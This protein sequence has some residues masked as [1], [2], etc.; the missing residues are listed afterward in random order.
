[1][2]TQN[3]SRQSSTSNLAFV[4]RLACDTVSLGFIFCIVPVVVQHVLFPAGSDFLA[5]TF[6]LLLVALPANA[7]IIFFFNKWT[8]RVLS[9]T[10]ISVNITL[11]DN[12]IMLVA[13]YVAGSGGRLDILFVTSNIL[14]LVCNFNCASVARSTKE[15]ILLFW[16]IDRPIKEKPATYV[17]LLLVAGMIA[18]CLVDWRLVYL[19]AVLLVLVLPM[20]VSKVQRAMKTRV[21]V[22]PD[23][24]KR[25]SRAFTAPVF[26]RSTLSHVV[27]KTALAVLFIFTLGAVFS[28]P[29]LPVCREMVLPG[30]S[31]LPLT[32]TLLVYTLAFFTLGSSLMILFWWL[33]RRHHADRAV[34]E[35]IAVICLFFAILGL[36]LPY[37]I[38]GIAGLIPAPAYQVWSLANN[39]FFAMEMLYVYLI[40]FEFIPSRRVEF[41]GQ[42]LPILIGTTF[43]LWV[44]PVADTLSTTSTFLVPGI[45]A[46]CL[47]LAYYLLLP[48]VRAGR[49]QRSQKAG[50]DGVPGT[51]NI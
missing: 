11:A 33:M 5:M 45:L 14:F 48:R 13:I 28:S 16:N 43:F 4:Y 44:F 23:I 31:T 40:I 7:F 15:N 39:T 26:T 24:A 42:F 27:E 22:D 10:F 50:S 8:P 9:I 18:V 29:M 46:A 38:D 36:A 19:I 35:K 34:R 49:I 12:I 3:A 41:F 17:A 1:M 20:T 2:R 47:L 25:Y 21:V 32:S 6:A 51:S 37:A 30:G